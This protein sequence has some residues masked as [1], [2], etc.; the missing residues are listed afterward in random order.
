MTCQS[1][2]GDRKERAMRKPEEYQK[3]LD[4]LRTE[5]WD[6]M[7]PDEAADIIQELIDKATP[8]IPINI[9]P[10]TFNNHGVGECPKCNTRVT[11]FDKFC[12]RCGQALKRSEQ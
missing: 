4:D 10:N 5:T 12:P 11:S 7:D 2:S 9:K 8:T 6:M 1:P 3:A